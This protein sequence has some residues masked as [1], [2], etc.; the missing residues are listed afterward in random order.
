MAHP[1]AP[2]IYRAFTLAL[3]ALCRRLGRMWGHGYCPSGPQS[4]HK[5]W[6]DQV[7]EGQEVK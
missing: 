6:L 2:Q 5:T 4:P 3:D 1:E 7:G